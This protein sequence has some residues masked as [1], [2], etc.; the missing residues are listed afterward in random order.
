MAVPGMDKWVVWF[1]LE[2][3]HT[4]PEQGQGPTPILS[5]GSGTGPGP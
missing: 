3:F 4:V 5:H 2:P 1:Y